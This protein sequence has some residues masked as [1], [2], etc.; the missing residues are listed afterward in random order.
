MG[1]G[2]LWIGAQWADACRII[3]PQILRP[4]GG[5]PCRPP[6]QRGIRNLRA[7]SLCFLQSPARAF[8]C[9]AGFQVPFL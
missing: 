8:M 6:F 9:R 2:G 4:P 3:L 5:T 7:I 1:Q